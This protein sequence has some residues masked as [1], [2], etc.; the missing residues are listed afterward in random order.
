LLAVNTG[1]EMPAK[2]KKVIHAQ[3]PPAEAPVRAA[4]F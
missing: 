4:P 2:V 3:R 1:T